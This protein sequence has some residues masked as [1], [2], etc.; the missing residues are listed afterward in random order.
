MPKGI[1]NGKRGGYNGKTRQQIFDTK[2]DKGPQHNGCWLWIGKLD[3]YGYGK[4]VVMAHRFSFQRYKGEIPKGSLVCHSCDNRACV[5]PDHLWAGTWAE[6]SAD[7]TAKRRQ[8]CGEKIGK[9]KLTLAA[10]K[11]IKLSGEPAA[12]L[13]VKFNVSAGAVHF[14]RSGRTWHH[15]K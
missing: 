3:R 12:A 10:V 5:N 15:V 7:M 9:A 11:E 13:A 6:N 1:H 2:V 8:A 4:F 14:V